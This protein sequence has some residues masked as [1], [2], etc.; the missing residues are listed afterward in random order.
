MTIIR[1]GAPAA[2]RPA[3]PTKT[4]QTGQPGPQGV[5]GPA[6]PQG[7]QGTPGAGFNYTHTQGS[8]SAV[9]TII[10]NLGG[11]PNVTTTTATG[12][13]FVADVKYDS[14]NQIT[15]TLAYSISGF[16]YLS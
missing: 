11:Y 4:V 1:P 3:D 12:E 8:P 7:P 13:E 10:H 16:A 6:G 9:W 5:P 15:V 14:P 2:I